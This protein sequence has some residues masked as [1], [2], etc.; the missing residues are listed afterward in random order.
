MLA[1]KTLRHM[2]TSD[3]YRYIFFWSLCCPACS[4]LIFSLMRSCHG[5]LDMIVFMHFLMLV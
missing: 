3:R 1:E 2:D 5:L 4:C